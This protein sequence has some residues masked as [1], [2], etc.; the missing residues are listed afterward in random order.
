MTSRIRIWSVAAALWALA[1]GLLALFWSVGGPGFPFG[2]ADPDPGIE[3]GMSILGGV[4]QASAAPWIAVGALSAAVVAGLL[5]VRTWP[6]LPGALFEAMAWAVAL[7][8]GV[9]L[10]DYRPLVAVGH[11]PVFL[12]GRPFGWPEGVTFASQ[13]P[14]PV[15]N[16]LICMIGGALFAA[17]ALAHRRARTGACAACGRDG[18]DRDP[19]RWGTVAVWIAAGVPVLYAASRW[20]WAL[21]VPFGF[22]AADLRQMDRE[23]PGI[24]WVGAAMGSMGLVGSV[25]TVG[26][27]R[28]WGEVFPRWVP[29]LAGRRVPVALVMVPALT[30]ALLVTSA[31]LMFAR[32]L[33]LDP[34]MGNWA[35]MGPAVLWPVWGAA[36]ATAAVAYRL[37][38]RRPCAVCAEPDGSDAPLNTRSVSS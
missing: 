4:H 12:V 16:Q 30:V 6:G 20:A 33:Y 1:Y 37:R 9:L 35:A 19:V 25:L 28:P 23:M 21:G 11:L 17:G 22:S 18:R 13:L 2:V 5:A 10:P 27:I 29:V 8:L 36:L 14:W 7:A 15:V 32:A 31:G 24:W 3:K 26:L 38:H 34:S